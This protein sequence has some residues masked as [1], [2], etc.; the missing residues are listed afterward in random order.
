MS[1]SKFYERFKN[2]SSTISTTGEISINPTRAIT[3]PLETKLH[4]S[5]MQNSGNYI[6]KSASPPPELRIKFNKSKNCFESTSLKSEI[7]HIQSSALPLNSFSENF[8][9]NPQYQSATPISKPGL[10]SSTNI[11]DLNKSYEKKNIDFVPYTINDYNCI[12]T[13]SYYQLGGLGPSTIGNQE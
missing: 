6:I 8:I 12:K 13:K 11:K 3:K 9:I 10:G 1:N 2:K 7:P 4:G 5:V